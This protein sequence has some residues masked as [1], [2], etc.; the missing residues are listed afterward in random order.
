MSDTPETNDNVEKL[1]KALVFA[2]LT[3]DPNA[4]GTIPV[5]LARKAAVVLDQCGVVQGEVSGEMTLPGWLTERLRE[6]AQPV[7]AEPDHTAVR[8]EKILRAPKPPRR[9]P[10]SRM[11]VAKATR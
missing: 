2:F 1:T 5:P 6:E 10:R 4:P 8:E 11:A 9:I 3:A 7:P